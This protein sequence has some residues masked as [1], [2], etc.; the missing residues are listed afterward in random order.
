MKMRIFI[1][2]SAAAVLSLSSCSMLPGGKVKLTNQVDSV[3]YALGYLEANAYVKQF[4]NQAFPFDTVDGKALV[5]AFSKAKFKADYWSL[6]KSQFDTLS[7]KIFIAAFNEQL[8]NG[9]N[10]IFNEMSADAVLQK[11][12]ES[13]RSKAEKAAKEEALKNL[14]VGRKFLEENKNKPGVITTES[15]LQYEIIKAGNGPKP[16]LADQ[17]KCHYHGTLIDGTVFDSSVERKEPAVFPVSGV[18][19]GWTEALQLMPV[20]SKWKLYVPSELAYGERAQG[21]KLKGNSTLIFEVE[22]L[23][24]VKK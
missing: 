2:L 20:G 16:T 19:R 13:T 21:A 17:V 14:E 18:I 7:E 8:A 15:G 6:R 23:E 4:D 1:A 3:S 22:L 5:N 10:S 12:F 11:K 24:I 9:K